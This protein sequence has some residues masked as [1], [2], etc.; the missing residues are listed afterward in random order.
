MYRH[1]LIATDGSA[2]AEKAVAQGL[3]LAQ[4]TRAKVTVL[5]VSE[6]LYIYGAVPNLHPLP[7][8][9]PSAIGEAKRHADEHA[10]TIL[11]AAAARAQGLGVPCATLAVAHDD[12]HAAIIENAASEGCDLIVMASHGRRGLSALV[13]GSVTLKVLTHS[14]IPVLVLR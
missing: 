3:E 10:A 9:M 6:P 4:A 11:G 12:P 7:A 13:L 2:L 14:T 8:D 1:I 5:T